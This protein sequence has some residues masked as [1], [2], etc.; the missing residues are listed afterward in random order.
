MLIFEIPID[1]FDSDDDITLTMCLRCPAAP[2]SGAK[3]YERIEA[4]CDIP[5]FKR[6][7]CDFCHGEGRVPA[8]AYP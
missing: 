7:P 6:I 4:P 5:M 3:R 1:F 2:G 8:G